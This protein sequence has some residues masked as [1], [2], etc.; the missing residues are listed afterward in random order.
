MKY[1]YALG[2]I[3]TIGL[4]SLIAAADEAIKTADVRI[5]TYEK[6]DAGIVT[7]YFVGDVA[8]VQ[9]AVAAGT[10]KAKEL[11]EYR[12]SNVIPRLDKN[13]LNHLTSNPFKKRERKRTVKQEHTEKK[14]GLNHDQGSEQ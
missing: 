7:V 13:V 14:L 12:S 9:E 5:I 11:G 1:H 4:T 8:A 3:E 2:M 6:P 10:K